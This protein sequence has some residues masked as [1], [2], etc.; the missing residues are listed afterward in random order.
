MDH[1]N[2]SNWSTFLCGTAFSE[3]QSW[4]SAELLVP[5]PRTLELVVLTPADALERQRVASHDRG[6]SAI[7]LAPRR[8]SRG[9]RQ[10]ER[11]GA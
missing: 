2:A 8:S 9:D 4:L 5:D 6:T 3:S 10:S 7:D 1:R 11:S